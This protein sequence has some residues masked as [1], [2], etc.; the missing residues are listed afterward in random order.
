MIG[1][2]PLSLYEAW[3]RVREM[4]ASYQLPRG[5]LATRVL[6]AS[7][8]LWQGRTWLSG[9]GGSSLFF[10]PMLV[11][12]GV[13][14]DLHEPS[15]LLFLCLH[16]KYSVHSART[17]G[18]PSTQAPKQLWRTSL[19]QGN[20]GELHVHAEGAALPPCRYRIAIL[21]SLSHALRYLSITLIGVIT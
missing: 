4:S 5:R 8:W 15:G 3:D 21:Q 18:R 12:D 2:Q 19:T 20:Q 16:C 11:T 1:S 7:G 14:I 17:L 10:T 6:A 13:I 9:F